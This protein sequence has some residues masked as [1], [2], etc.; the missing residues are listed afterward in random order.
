MCIPHHWY[1]VLLLCFLGGAGCAE[2]HACS[3]GKGSESWPQGA[4]EGAAVEPGVPLGGRV[5]Q[6][7]F[8]TA[9]MPSPSPGQG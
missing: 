2:E 1:S 4:S 7:H 3:M 9:P 6:G 8:C 5:A